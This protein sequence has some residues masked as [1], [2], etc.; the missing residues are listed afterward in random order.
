MINGSSKEPGYLSGFPHVVMAMI[1]GTENLRLAHDALSGMKTLY[2]RGVGADTTRS[3]FEHFQ[4]IPQL[5]YLMISQ[6]WDV[7][8]KIETQGPIHV[9]DD[10]MQDLVN[11]KDLK[12]IQLSAAQIE[13]GD[14]GI[15]ALAALGSLENIILS[16]SRITDTGVSS[17]TGLVNLKALY[18]SSDRI[19][20][21]GLNSLKSLK[22][23]ETLCVGSARLDQE[24]GT[25][26][27]VD[28]PKT[29]I[30]IYKNKP[31]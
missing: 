19:T 24:D 20:G 8:G 6:G 22:N 11:L 1:Q 27:G 31:K 21:T 14:R 25:K 10:L 9:N 23:L 28:L 12:V 4:H 3:V 30:Q 26:L 13:L 16:E 29:N 15:Q 18:L 7:A 2:L 17:L 5:M